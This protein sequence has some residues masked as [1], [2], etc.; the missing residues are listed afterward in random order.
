LPLASPAEAATGV[1]LPRLGLEVLPGSDRR[2][3]LAADA[4]S[5]TSP[6][7]TTVTNFA[8][9][10]VIATVSQVDSAP[11]TS[12]RVAAVRRRVT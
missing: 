9:E 7:R 11:L 5:L 3:R 10:E 2:F 6:N 8:A 12:V 4:A 1:E